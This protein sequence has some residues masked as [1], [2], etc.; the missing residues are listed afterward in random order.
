VKF[1]PDSRFHWWLWGRPRTRTPA[2]SADPLILIA[3]PDEDNRALY[4]EA[5]RAAGYVVSGAPMTMN[6]RWQPLEVPWV[7]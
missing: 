4:H 1:G 5:V 3:D 7:T 2:I 6:W